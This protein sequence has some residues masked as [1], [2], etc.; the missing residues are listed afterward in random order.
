MERLTRLSELLTSALGAGI[1]SLLRDEQISEVRLNSDGTIWGNRLGQGKFQASLTISPENARRAIY[2]VAYGVGD[3]CNES[4]PSIAAELPL[5][6][7]RFQG[8]IPPLSK[9][10]VFVIRKKAVRIFT[11]EDLLA[12]GVVSPDGVQALRS[13]VLGR[14][15]ILVVGGTDSGKTTFANALLRVVE[16]TTDRIVILE[17][18]QELQCRALDVEY[19]HTKDGVASLR[20]LVR[21]TL[22]LSPDRIVI[23]EVRGPEALDLL[24]AW[25]TGHPGGVSTVHA[26]SAER[27]LLRLEQLVQE[28]GVTPSRAMIAEAV[29]VLVYME[30]VGT[31]RVVKDVMSIRGMKKDQY[32]LVPLIESQKSR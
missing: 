28:S 18:T 6:G 13:A 29:N 20:D 5:S 10:P 19:L 16:E 2:A 26:N 15:N 1:A 25:N 31:K 8:V 22:R 4:K 32:D 24:K 17:D 27:G 11:L 9:S 7:E 14:K 21:Y 23:G 12:Q 30:K 3:I